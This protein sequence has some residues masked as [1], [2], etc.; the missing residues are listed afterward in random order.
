MNLRSLA[1]IWSVDLYEVLDDW[2]RLE[3]GMGPAPHDP[4]ETL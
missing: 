2:V 1:P 3:K 4:P